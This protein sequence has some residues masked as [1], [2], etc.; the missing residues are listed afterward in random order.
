LLHE[1]YSSTLVVALNIHHPP[2]FQAVLVP[3]DAEVQCKQLIGPTYEPPTDFTTLH[4]LNCGHSIPMIMF[5]SHL[6][7]KLCKETCT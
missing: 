7:S 1:K 3:R 4:R 6:L 2:F 5:V